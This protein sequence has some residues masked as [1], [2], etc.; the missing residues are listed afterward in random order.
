SLTLLVATVA[1]TAVHR[2]AAAP[3][4][5]ALGTN[6]GA[7]IAKTMVGLFFEDINFAADG[8][9]YP[10][11]VKNRSFE[12]P[13]ALM[14][15][16]RATPA[17]GTFTVRTDAPVSPK[18]THYLRIEGTDP[19]QPF[20]VM[21]DGFRGVAVEAGKSYVFSVV[22][23]RVGN[24]PSALRLQVVGGL[25][26]VFATGRVDGIGPTW[27][28]HSV[29]IV[30]KETQASGRLAV[31]LDGPGAMDVDVVSLFPVE[32]YKNRPGGLRKDLGELLQEMH[33]GFLR[34]PGGCIVEGRYLEYRY[35]WKT[36]IGDPND[37]KLIINRW[38]DEFP[39]K[40]APDYYQSYGLGFFEYFQLAE[41]I[42]AEPL[43]ILNCGMAC[44]FNSAELAPMNRLDQYIQDAL[45]LIEFANGPTTSTWGKRRAQLGHPAPFD[46]KLLGVGNEQWG[47]DYL[48]RFEA[49]QKALKAKYPE[50]QLVAS[51]DPFTDRPAAKEQSAALRKLN[52]DLIDEHFYRTPEW[53]FGHASQYDAYPRTGS[54]IFVGEYAAHTTPVGSGDSRNIWQAALSE[55]AFL[56]GLERNADVVRMSAYAPLFA[57][58]DAWQWTPNLIWFDNLRSFATPNYYVQQLFAANRGEHV[59]PITRDGKPV[60]G[61]DGLFASAVA[62]N[63]GQAFVVKLVNSTGEPMPIRIEVPG[64]ST[65]AGEAV[66]IA[67]DPLAENS[68]AHP[69]RVKPKQERVALNAGVIE[70]TLPAYSVTVLRPAR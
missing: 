55:A 11:R 44:Q 13:D 10:E 64:G 70:R 40:P 51:A 49:F 4:T 14:G 47:P 26:T 32:T 67:A 66:F 33:P 24:G 53:F 36:T 50:V 31:F 16:K 12:F 63:N 15:W 9:L 17:A 2:P 58:T 18:N 29:T 39:H 8:G 21:N 52:A 27:Q 48:P 28:R 57:H 62:V 65:A 34:F 42:G 38:N 20:G 7:P 5:L 60:E 45:D 3:I 41:D 6:P 69:D 59:L 68:L 43:P 19:A 25:Q 37:R 23:R 35:Q 1:A 56:T 30:P 54:K 22:A 46:M 61:Q